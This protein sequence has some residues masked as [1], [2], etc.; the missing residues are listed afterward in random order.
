[1]WKP[2][3]SGGARLRTRAGGPRSDASRLGA[4]AP[5]QPDASRM[6]RRFIQG[7]V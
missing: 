7:D 3:S 5:R 4:G 6:P 1:M 2:A